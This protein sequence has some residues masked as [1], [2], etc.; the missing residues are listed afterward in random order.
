[1]IKNKY[2]L[3]KLIFIVWGESDSEQH[4]FPVSVAKY[5][6]SKYKLLS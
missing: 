5:K 4:N 3:F 2:F 1:M 6:T